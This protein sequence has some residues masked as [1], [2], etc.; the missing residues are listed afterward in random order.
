MLCAVKVIAEKRRRRLD[1]TGSLDGATITSSGHLL[2]NMQQ[3]QRRATP[4]ALTPTCSDRVSSVEHTETPTT[5]D[6]SQIISVISP[7]RCSVAAAD[8]ISATVAVGVPCPV[9]MPCPR[10]GSLA[11]DADALGGVQSPQQCCCADDSLSSCAAA[12]VLANRPTTATASADSST[13]VDFSSTDRCSVS[14][15]PTSR[16]L[17]LSIPSLRQRSADLLS[18]SDDAVVSTRSVTETVSGLMSAEHLPA[19]TDRS[20]LAASDDIQRTSSEQIAMEVD[21]RQSSGQ[22]RVWTAHSSDIQLSDSVSCELIE[23]AD[24]TRP[25]AASLLR[26]PAPTAITA[27]RVLRPLASRPHLCYTPRTCLQ[28]R[29]LRSGNLSSPY[30]ASVRRK[31]AAQE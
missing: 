7:D 3:Q 24:V 26:R 13:A 27:A 6:S 8:P 25:G 23:M 1:S 17:S 4:P 2:M 20:R 19:A 9:G 11:D 5:P 30:N 15:S 29:R 31:S 12:V 21:E 22:S 10:R 14:A 16:T 18:S 28:V